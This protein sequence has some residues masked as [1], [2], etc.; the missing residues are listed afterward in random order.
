M[1]VGALVVVAI[2]FTNSVGRTQQ[3]ATLNNFYNALQERQ[4]KDVAIAPDSITWTLKDDR[5]FKGDAPWYGP[6]DPGPGSA[7]RLGER[8]GRRQAA[9]ILY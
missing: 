4:L 5:V 8:A 2:L 9:T 6:P 7:A 3:S 1:I